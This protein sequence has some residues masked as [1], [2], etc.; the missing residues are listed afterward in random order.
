M[1]TLVFFK[2][3]GLLDSEVG[4]LVEI[5]IPEGM[6]AYINKMKK[7]ARS[8]NKDLRSLI[9]HKFCALSRQFMEQLG[10]EYL[11][12]ESKKVNAAREKKLKLPKPFPSRQS[13][14]DRWMIGLQDII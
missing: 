7:Y 2:I 1:I 6:F 8:I 5:C 14:E 11:Q 9:L 10:N 4:K 3:R 13:I 12:A